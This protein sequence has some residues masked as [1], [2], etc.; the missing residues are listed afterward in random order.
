M[1]TILSSVCSPDRGKGES[2][3]EER[4]N[5][6]CLHG[7]VRGG[8]RRGCEK[9]CCNIAG[10]GSVRKR[11]PNFPDAKLSWNGEACRKCFPARE[12]PLSGEW[13]IGPPGA[14]CHRGL[15]L[16]PLLMKQVVTQSDIGFTGR[17]RESPLANATCILCGS[18]RNRLHTRDA[19]RSVDRD[20]LWQRLGRVAVGRSRACDRIFWRDK[21]SAS[22]PGPSHIYNVGKA[23]PESCGGEYPGALTGHETCF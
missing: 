1:A 15:E 21:V 4:Q 9:I 16:G 17:R 19:E 2:F 14:F 5:G 12:G 23:P 18:E 7:A 20:C 11:F 10:L 22:E 8:A 6:H 3:H 13:R